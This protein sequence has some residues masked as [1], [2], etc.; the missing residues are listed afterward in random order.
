MAWTYK[1]KAGSDDVLVVVAIGKAC[2]RDRS[3]TIDALQRASARFGFRL[4]VVDTVEPPYRDAPPIRHLIL[5]DDRP[6]DPDTVAAVEGLLGLYTSAS[7]A[8]AYPSAPA[9]WAAETAVEAVKARCGLSLN[10]F[11]PDVVAD[12][13]I[14]VS[15]Q[16][17]ADNAVCDT[18]RVK[19]DPLQE[20][21]DAALSDTEARFF[22]AASRVFADEGL[23]LRAPT[24]GYLALRR[25]TGFLITAT[26]TDKVA[27]DLQRIS[28]VTGYD[29]SANRIRYNG[30]F[31]PSSDSVEAAVILGADP[32]IRAIVHTHA[33]RLFTRNP[34][35]AGRRLVPP[36]PYGEPALGDAVAAALSRAGDG[37]LIM[38]DHGEIFAG[39]EPMDLLDAIVDA[40]G[41]ARLTLAP[42]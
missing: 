26:R 4:H 2:R 17:I 33:S 22:L 23:F 3:G 40:S 37:F 29:R 16:K 41:K 38:E 34:A 27:L 14:V 20:G 7:I 36:M 21:G 19:Y 28:H 31:L 30:A 1:T 39:R 32:S 15:D 35:Y 24:D 10:I 13:W 6:F 11:F 5:V 42:A 8:F 12:G 9:L 18:V 25:D